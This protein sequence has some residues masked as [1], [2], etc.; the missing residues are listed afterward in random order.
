M[1]AIVQ[2]LFVECN[3]LKTVKMFSVPLRAPV[4]PRLSVIFAYLSMKVNREEGD[5]LA[6]Q[7][8]CPFFETSAALRHFVDDAFHSVVRQIR[9][10]EH[11]LT[12]SHA[13]KHSK[14]SPNGIGRDFGKVLRKIFR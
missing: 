5:A 9:H 6:S 12:G 1:S 14:K 4:C 10:R 8:D 2:F 3:S 7:W 11:E 13:L